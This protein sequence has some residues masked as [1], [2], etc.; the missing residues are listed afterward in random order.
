[1]ALTLTNAA[2]DFQIVKPWSPNIKNHPKPLD[3]KLGQLL[4]EQF[5]LLIENED[6]N[7]HYNL[8]WIKTALRIYHK[9]REL[10]ADQFNK[11]FKDT[12]KILLNL[13]QQT[14][15]AFDIL[16]VCC[17]SCTKSDNSCKPSA[18]KSERSLRICRDELNQ[19]KS[20]VIDIDSP[21]Q[22]LNSVKEKLTLMMSSYLTNINDPEIAKKCKNCNL[23]SIN[24]RRVLISTNL[25][26]LH[27][28]IQ[29][30]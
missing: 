17:P 22:C 8:D 7:S 23:L 29:C 10:T 5:L 1:M 9:D 13:S 16:G 28:S 20:S 25:K 27:L 24:I 12:T 6:L 21:E 15:A 26:S 14:Q 4:L 3:P 2:N 18:K 30:F 19:L 11:I